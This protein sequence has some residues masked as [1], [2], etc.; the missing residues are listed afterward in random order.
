MIRIAVPLVLSALSSLAFSMPFTPKGGLG[1]NST[2]PVYR[3]LS[4][5]DRQSLV[6]MSQLNVIAL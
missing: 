3:P 2:P 5:F 1:T 4:D 6:S